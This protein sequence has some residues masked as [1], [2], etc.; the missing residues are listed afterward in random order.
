MML[1]RIERKYWKLVI[2]SNNLEAAI[3]NDGLLYM[4]YIED[5]IEHLKDLPKDDSGWYF[6][7]S[8][9][10]YCVEWKDDNKVTVNPSKVFEIFGEYPTEI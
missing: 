3:S 2:F 6:N 5:I 4:F 9:D 7:S 10:R 1:S 8:L